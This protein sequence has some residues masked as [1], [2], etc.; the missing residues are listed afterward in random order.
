VGGV[1]E[2]QT[3]RP[4]YQ[5]CFTTPT[6]IVAN[7]V[8]DTNT[9]TNYKLSISRCTVL[10][11]F[12]QTSNTMT[13]Q[14]DAWDS[15]LYAKHG[16]FVPKESGTIVKLLDLQ[17]TDVVLDLGCGAGRLSLHLQSQCQHLTGVDASARMIEAARQKGVE[18]VRVANATRLIE[19]GIEKEYYDKVFSNACLHWIKDE[20]QD[21]H[22]QSVYA[23]LKP[24]GKFVFKMGAHQKYCCHSYGIDRCT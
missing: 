13:Q 2:K 16:Y 20:H 10:G 22:I 12:F 9:L 1:K 3:N 15:E 14:A 19:D 17:L 6:T 18:H 8:C 7:H 11:S 24:G 23:C 21:N 4:H 5:T